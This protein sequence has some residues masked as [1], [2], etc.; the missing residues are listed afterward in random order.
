[1]DT[2]TL[3][4]QYIIH[5]SFNSRIGCAMVPP[6]DGSE[7]LSW[8]SGPMATT[9]T[10]PLQMTLAS[11]EFPTLGFQFGTAQRLGAGVQSITKRGP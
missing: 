10:M 7:K 1:M 2:V 3:R 9:A 8:A 6:R 11:G 4:L 5:S